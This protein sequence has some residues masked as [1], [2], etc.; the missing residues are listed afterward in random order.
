M[1]GR[2]GETFVNS[3]IRQESQVAG[4][5]Q[6]YQE[7]LNRGAQYA[8]DNDWRRAARHFEIARAEFPDDPTP[9]KRLGQTHFELN[10]YPNALRFYQQA[11]RL[12]PTD[13]VTLGRI[14]DVFERLG[15]IDE[16]ALTYMAVAEAHIK[17]RDLDATVSHWERAT[18]LDPNLV[19]AR[20]RLALVYHR[21]GRIR[22][23]IREHLALARIYQARGD[24][25]QAA[26]VCKA[27]LDMDPNNPDV[28]RAVELLRQGVTMQEPVSPDSSPA[29]P[30]KPAP[31]AFT[32]AE[33]L[34]TAAEAFE[35][36]EVAGWDERPEVVDVERGSPVEDARQA[37]LADLAGSFFEDDLAGA[38]AAM[39]KTGR[40]A[41]ISKAIACQTRGQVDEA[42]A[43]YERAM[44][45][46]VRQPAAH[47]NLG[48]LYQERLRLDE[49]ISQLELSL[50]DSEYKLGS[51]FALG[52]CYRAKGKFDEA[53]T[54]FM[55]V[56]KI[57]DMRTVKREQ[58]DDLMRLYESLADTYAVRG[59]QEQAVAFTN[60]LVDFLSTKGWEDKVKES[61]ERLDAL[62]EGGQT[63]SLAEILTVPGSEQLLESISL[64]SEYVRR[65]WLDTA[66]EECYRAVQMAPFY[67]P[68]H[69]QL[70]KLLEQR[71][72]IEAAGNKYVAVAQVYRTRGD[73][74]RAMDA[75]ERAMVLAPLDMALRTRLIE[76][77]KRHGEID[78][79][80]EH[81]AALAE[82]Y[83]QLAQIDKARDKYQETLKL[84]P[85]GSPEKQ[86]T[87]RILHRIADI[88]MQRLSWREAVG[89]YYQIVQISPD[90]ER[91]SVTLVELL[92]KMGQSHQ[93]LAELDRFLARLAAQGRTKKILAILNDMISQQ[94]DNMGLLNRSAAAYA[95]AGK[96]DKAMT[97]LDR[98]GELQL[99][100]GLRAEAANTVR[101]ILSLQPA[102]VAG[103]RK[104]LQQIVGAP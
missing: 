50:E 9:F 104:L 1:N 51:H 12:D 43:V 7:A 8:W 13:V 92:F 90:D 47:F 34:R 73:L 59:E 64:T 17:S 79:A 42:I 102:D 32:M 58:V 84:A 46:G 95:Q 26:V 94:P 93:A 18:R 63:M 25:Q 98:L 28:L 82:S 20:Q 54:H 55:Q 72:Q 5:R 2:G 6:R 99:D 76:M 44:E 35:S 77:L 57:V 101:V 45:G 14:A 96:R 85:R 91:A 86:W 39:N 3:Q 70:A 49:A 52:E 15:R 89:A 87:L 36:D 62:T 37:A 75:F 16:A 88:D 69:L 61:R 38:G 33:A 97:H 40:D 53:L 4:N 67:L 65:G 29:E 74:R 83:Y 103:Y 68:I 48:L 24:I 31:V 23:S 19:S 11:A 100:A 80:L 78:R 66:A 21:Q 27:A 60:A 71:G 30:E 41:L 56:A 22:E 81:S 10:E